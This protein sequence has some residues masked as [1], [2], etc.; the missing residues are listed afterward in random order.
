MEQ[1]EADDAIGIFA[2]ANPGN[3]VVS[4]DKDPK[5]IPGKFMT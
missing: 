4:P 2:T 5:Q 1:L 3:V